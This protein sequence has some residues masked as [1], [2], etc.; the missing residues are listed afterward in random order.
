MSLL[1]LKL[2]NGVPL[3]LATISKLLTSQSYQVPVTRLCPPPPDTMLLQ[4]LFW[5]QGFFIC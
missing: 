1:Y 3:P 2:S 4:T 5:P